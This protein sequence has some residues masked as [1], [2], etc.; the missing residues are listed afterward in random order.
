MYILK[1]NIPISEPTQSFA[2][3]HN[4][5]MLPKAH[6]EASIVLLVGHCN[7]ISGLGAFCNDQICVFCFHA[8]QSTFYS[9]LANIYASEKT[10]CYIFHKD[11][12]EYS[13][14]PSFQGP[15]FGQASY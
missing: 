12:L 10:F 2:Y 7:A 15:S 14:F 3:I 8:L 1:Q 4:T 13:V 5:R 11:R 9:F 6:L